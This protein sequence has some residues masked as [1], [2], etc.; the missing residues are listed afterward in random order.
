MS[1]VKFTRGSNGLLSI[2]LMRILSVFTKPPCLPKAFL[3]STM[4]WI[5]M[6]PYQKL[7]VLKSSNYIQER[8]KNL[9]LKCYLVKTRMTAQFS[10]VSK[11][12]VVKRMSHKWWKASAA[13]KKALLLTWEKATKK[14]MVIPIEQ[15]SLI[16][17]RIFYLHFGAHS[18]TTSE[19]SMTKRFSTTY[20]SWRRS[21]TRSV[22]ILMTTN[23]SWL[24]SSSIPT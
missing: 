11:S 13:K 20:R 19:D 5:L 23:N 17:Q 8:K 22:S 7:L 4:R 15:K 1:F 24:R 6:K 14:R 3:N 2:S 10:T 9:L 18:S 21:R 16:L 12:L